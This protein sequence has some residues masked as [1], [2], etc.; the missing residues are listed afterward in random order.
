MPEKYHTVIELPTRRCNANKRRSPLRWKSFFTRGGSSISLGTPRP[1][2]NSEPIIPL[3]N[4]V[5]SRNVLNLFKKKS[6]N[7][8]NLYTINI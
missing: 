6:I 1:R 8:I 5:V 2:K 3:Q 4:K 7:I